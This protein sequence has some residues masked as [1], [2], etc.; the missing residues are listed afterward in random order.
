MTFE[1]AQEQF[2]KEHPNAPITH[3]PMVAYHMF[4]TWY[5][6]QT[7]ENDNDIRES[8]TLSDPSDS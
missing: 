1:E 4:R 8:D 5:W 6:A 3:Q 7:L 2:L